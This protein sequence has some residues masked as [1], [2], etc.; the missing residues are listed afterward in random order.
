MVNDAFRAPPV[1]QP[2]KRHRALPPTHPPD[3]G[4]WGSVQG[5]FRFRF[6]FRFEFRFSAESSAVFLRPAAVDSIPAVAGA[7]VIINND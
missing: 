2:N 7:A 6:G 1:F 5:G 3:T 4:L